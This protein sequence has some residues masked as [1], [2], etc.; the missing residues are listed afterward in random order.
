[1]LCT[2]RL[3]DKSR[4]HLVLPHLDILARTALPASKRILARYIA[5]LVIILVIFQFPLHVWKKDTWLLGHSSITEE[6][7]SLIKVLLRTRTLRS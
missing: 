6:N 5:F 2:V 1:M 3:Q 7:L 4:E